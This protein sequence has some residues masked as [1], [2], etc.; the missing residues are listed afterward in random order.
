MDIRQPKDYKVRK[1]L[2]ASRRCPQ[3]GRNFVPRY[4]SEKVHPD[5][6]R[7]W[8]RGYNR[9]YQRDVRRDLKRTWEELNRETGTQ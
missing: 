2:F 4:A 7:R 6:R 1:R 8:Y 9:R 5:C 3:C